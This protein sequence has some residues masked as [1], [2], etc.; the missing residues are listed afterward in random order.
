MSDNN[1]V[2]NVSTANESEISAGKLAEKKGTS[3]AVRDLGKLLVTDHS[4]ALADIRSLEK[5]QKL[6]SKT[7]PADTSAKEARDFMQ[8]LTST[9]KGAGWD[10]TFVQHE[11]QDHQQDIAD[12]QAMQNQAK[13]DQLKQAL[14]SS[15]PTL[16]KHLQAAQDALTKI[17]SDT[18]STSN[19]K[20]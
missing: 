17:G 1:I 13:N 6:P 20:S 4:K 7:L 10:S 3:S 8:K 5:S 19:K 18:T 16:Q 12:T 14:G 11:I 15:I 2:A 9:P